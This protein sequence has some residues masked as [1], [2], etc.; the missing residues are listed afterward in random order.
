MDSDR[1]RRSLSV[2]ANWLKVF[3]FFQ[4]CE[5]GTLLKKSRATFQL[6]YFLDF[7]VGSHRFS[8]L[9]GTKCQ[10][11]G[12]CPLLTHAWFIP[13]NQNAVMVFQKY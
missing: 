10:V 11:N 6:L 4:K 12:R 13:I 2:H 1:P 7:D 3:F 9:S 5:I 8:R